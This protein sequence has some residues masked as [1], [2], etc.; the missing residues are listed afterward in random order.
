MLTVPNSWQVRKTE[1]WKVSVPEGKAQD[2]LWGS[3][4]NSGRRCLAA[5]ATDNNQA[6][7]RNPNPNFLVQISSGRVGVFH[8]NG[9]GAKK[10]R[11]VLRIS[12]KRNSLAGYPGTFARIF[13]GCPKSLRKNRLCSILAP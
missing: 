10:V 12:G 8:V 3:E 13:L 5:L 4:T 9:V 6:R 11:Y 1:V 2:L 7:K